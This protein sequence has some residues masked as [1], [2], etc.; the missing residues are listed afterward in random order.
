MEGDLS[1]LKQVLLNLVWNAAEAIGTAGGVIEI[2]TGTSY[3]ACCT[4]QTPGH[5][6]GT[7]APGSY[8]W[9]DVRDTGCGIAA[10]VLSRMFDP[11]FTTKD[12]GRG[13]GLSAVAGIVRSHGGVCCVTSRLGAGTSI[14]VYLA[15]IV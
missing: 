5:Y 12:M 10:D 13:L 14:R 2:G 8:V 6:C 9:L 11:F 7:L 15:A 3:G 4:T 1:Q